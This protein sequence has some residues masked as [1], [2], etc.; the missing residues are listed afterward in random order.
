MKL[1]NF[2]CFTST[3]SLSQTEAKTR[4]PRGT[5]QYAG[6]AAS[7]NIDDAVPLTLLTLFE[8]LAVN[9]HGILQLAISTVI[10]AGTLLFFIKMRLD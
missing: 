2:Q 7:T 10:S 9:V 5:T 3:H 4:I 1:L 6:T 8:K